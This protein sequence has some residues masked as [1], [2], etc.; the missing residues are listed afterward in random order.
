MDLQS[1][2]CSCRSDAHACTCSGAAP[3]AML[4]EALPWLVSCTAATQLLGNS[5][6]SCQHSLWYIV[7]ACLASGCCEMVNALHFACQALPEPATPAGNCYNAGN[8]TQVVC[9]ALTVCKRLFE[10]H[11]M[12]ACGIGVSFEC[13][14]P[15]LVWMLVSYIVATYLYSDTVLVSGLHWLRVFDMGHAILH[16]PPLLYEGIVCKCCH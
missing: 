9:L 16:V 7:H 10:Y 3:V 12:R 13:L 15:R 1:L 2:C 5:A 4:S 14:H 11:G 6:M 8:M